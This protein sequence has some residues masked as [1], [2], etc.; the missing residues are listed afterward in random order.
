MPN[1]ILVG[2]QWGDEGKG[3]IIDLLTEKSDI[4]VRFQG[5]NNAGHTVRFENEKFVLHLIPSGILRPGKICLLGNGVVVDPDALFEEIRTLEAK[6]IRT[7]K[8]VFVSEQAHLIFPYHKQLDRLHEEAKGRQKIGTTQRGIGPCYA[9]KVGRTGIRIA[10]LYDL[11]SLRKRLAAIVAEKNKLLRNVYGVRGASFHDILRGVMRYRTRLLAIALNTAL[12]L[13]QAIR[14]GKRVLFEGAQGTLL[15]V[16]HGTYPYVTSSNTSAGAALTGTGIGPTAVHEVMGV[17]KAYTTRVGEGPFPTEFEKVL[18]E[19]IRDVG[20]EYGAT[21]GRP[22]RCGWFDAVIARHAVLVN[23]LSKLAVMK[24]DVLDSLPEVKICVGYRHRGRRLNSFP[25][26]VQT[27]SEVTP[28]YETHPGWRAPTIHA[29]RF[30]DLPPRARAYVK[31]LERILAVPI[32]ILS[33]GSKRNQ[34]IFL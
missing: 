24:L 28:I 11:P 2:A 14:R 19:K 4:I 33:V 7:A 34:T 10:D 23:G 21:T 27:L 30:R 9:D 31:R 12:F 15:D 13:N 18:M 22:R 3:K 8:R 5:G 16:D 25:A 1:I 6:G 26:N 20:E 29:R 32:S 17:L